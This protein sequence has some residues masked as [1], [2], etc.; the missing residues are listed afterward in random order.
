MSTQSTNL[1]PSISGDLRLPV[2]VLSGFLGAGK[3]TL[4]NHILK[5]REGKRVAVIV[6]DMS[7]LNIDAALIANGGANLSRT[8]EKLIEMSNGCICC[9]LRE[10][11]LV[12]ITRLAQEKR[13]DALLIESTGISEPLPVAETFTFAD[14]QGVTLSDI[15]RLDTLV[16]VVDGKNFLRDYTESPHLFERDNT[17][18]SSDT[19]TLTELLVE[20]VEFANVIVLNKT[21][22]LSS[23]DIAHLEGLL[24]KL[25]PVARLIKA[26]RSQVPLEDI[27]DTHLFNLEQAS[28]APGWKAVLRGHEKSEA[29]EYGF[30]SF[31]YRASE[32]FH[33]QR[34]NAFVDSNCE[35]IARSKGTLWLASRS[36]YAISWSQAGGS[37]QLD[38]LASWSQI[39]TDTSTKRGQELVIIGRFLDK[40]KVCDALERCLL[41]SSEKAAG[42]AVG[43]AFHDT[44]PVWDTRPIEEESDTP[45]GDLIFEPCIR[46]ELTLLETELVEAANGEALLMFAQKE[47][48]QSNFGKAVYALEGLVSKNLVSDLIENAMVQYQLAL[49]YVE[50]GEHHRDPPLLRSAIKTIQMQDEPW[51]TCEALSHLADVYLVTGHYAGAQNAFLAGLELA[52]SNKLV[53]WESTFEYELAGIDLE[54]EEYTKAQVR[55]ERSL[56]IRTHLGAHDL[57]PQVLKALEIAKKMMV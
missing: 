11:L 24:R 32:P 37:C 38:P 47:L 20:Q 5:N 10:D 16:T 53:A 15:A 43:S 28:E 29:D 57:I 45:S 34:F 51:M 52:K 40:E 8:E 2:T 7:E 36:D 21:D 17:I 39:E 6:N 49:V 44:F 9:T 3:T 12:E 4:L 54:S 26:E 48:A 1:N 33:P 22:L 13:F 35:T 14:E 42:E 31:V 55:L 46:L 19:R 56:E 27:L 30:S 25:N 18:E 50:I 41:N 23:V